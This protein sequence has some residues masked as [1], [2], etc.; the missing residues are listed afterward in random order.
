M[1][2][3]QTAIRFAELGLMPDAIIR[4]GIRNL[5][6]ARLKQIADGDCENAAEIKQ[7]FISQMDNAPIALVPELAN[8]QHY[9]IPAEFYAYTLG[10]HRKYSSCYWAPGTQTLDQAEQLALEISCE[11]ADLSDGQQVLELG[12][13]WG[14]LTLFMAARYPESLITAVSNS[15]SQREYI[16]RTAAER[17]LHNVSVITCDLNNFKPEEVFDRVVSVEMFEHMRNHRALLGRIGEWLKPGGKFFMHI[18]CHRST[19]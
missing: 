12:C 19:P 18:F 1:S 11:H 9:E 8:A 7:R 15:H 3:A 5:S 6:R 14:S 4:A 17:G 16:T 13:G 2:F 10:I